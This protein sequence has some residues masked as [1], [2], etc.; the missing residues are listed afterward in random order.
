AS[1][2]VVG[3]TTP[4]GERDEPMRGVTRVGRID[5]AC[6]L[7]AT[8]AKKTKEVPAPSAAHLPV[9]PTDVAPVDTFKEAVKKRA[10]SLKPYQI[11]AADFDIGFI[12][13]V[14]NYAAQSQP[15]Q[16][17]SNWSDYV[18]DIPQ[19]LF[20]RVTPKM[21]ESFLAKMEIGRAS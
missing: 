13:P 6:E 20:I 15:N 8:A 19:L 12:T 21:T 1:G 11:A 17:F 16:T 9:E 5:G 4:P 3:I 7:V 2:D 14:L 18:S 10:G